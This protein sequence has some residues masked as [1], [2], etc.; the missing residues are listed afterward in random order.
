ML[1]RSFSAVKY[2]AKNNYHGIVELLLK[3]GADVDHVDFVSDDVDFI[4]RFHSPS[5]VF[6]LTIQL[7][8]L[9]DIFFCD[10]FLSEWRHS[11][12]SCCWRWLF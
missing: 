2:A 9:H 8:A 11:T 7:F 12:V 6:C 4:F 5:A 1:Q 3:A 10:F